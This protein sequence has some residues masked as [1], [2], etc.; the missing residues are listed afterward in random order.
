MPS[1]SSGIYFPILIL[2]FV[3]LGFNAS[4]SFFFTVCWFLNLGFGRLVIN[5]YV[6]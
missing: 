1:I 2:F 5:A 6:N 4:S 3:I